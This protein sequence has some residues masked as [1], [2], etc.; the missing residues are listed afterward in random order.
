MSASDDVPG[1]F[2]ALS[3]ALTGHALSELWQ[4]GLV[5]A[6]LAELRRVIPAAV[7]D[8]L[9]RGGDAVARE[10]ETA[11]TAVLGD[12]DIGPVARSLTALWYLGTW[13]PLPDAWRARHGEHPD[14]R[15][16]V[17]SPE[18]HVD[19]LVWDVLAAP[20]MGARGPGF[21]TWAL[22]PRRSP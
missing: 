5:P 17:V 18:A 1:W 4:T 20:P 15:P 22:P 16:R 9:A 11:L 8:A 7:L 6:H 14:D 13:L 12:D 10:G 3:A 21:G 19:A 2:V